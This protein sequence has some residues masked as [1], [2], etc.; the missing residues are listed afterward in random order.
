MNGSGTTITQVRPT[1]E[2]PPDLEP[3]QW[4]AHDTADWLAQHP[5]YLTGFEERWVA[6][7]GPWIVAHSSDL[8]EAA[9]QARKRGVDDPL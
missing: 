7:V 6:M 9:K 2:C 1:T 8:A 5:G 4:T 3:N